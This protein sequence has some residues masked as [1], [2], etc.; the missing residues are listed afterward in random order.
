MDTILAKHMTT[1]QTGLNGIFDVLGRTRPIFDS[2]VAGVTV[3]GK[4]QM[5]QIRNVIRAGESIPTQ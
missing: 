1:L 3:I 4:S 2:I 5:D